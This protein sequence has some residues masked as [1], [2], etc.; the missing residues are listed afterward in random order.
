MSRKLSGIGTHG[1][2]VGDIQRPLVSVGCD[3]G[4]VDEV[5]GQGN[6]LAVKRV[7]LNHGPQQTGGSMT[8][9]GGCL[10]LG[11]SLRPSTVAWN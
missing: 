2:I 7:Q 10:C 5:Y 8:E 11:L 9:R 6:A 3:P 4:N 1:G